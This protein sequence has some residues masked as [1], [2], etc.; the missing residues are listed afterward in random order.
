MCGFV[1]YISDVPKEINSNWKETF[2]NMND[3]ITHRGP[4]DYGYFFDEHV[5]FGFRRLSIIDL[6]SGHQPLCYEN[7]RYWI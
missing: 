3:L 4:D 7:E 1:G 5:S 6:E 2:Q